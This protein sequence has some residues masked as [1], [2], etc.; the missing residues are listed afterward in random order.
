M[1]FTITV[2]MQD[3][4]VPHFLG[5]LQTMQ[6]L[7]SIGSS[8]VVG[9]YADGDGDFRPKFTVGKKPIR[10]MKFTKPLYGCEKPRSERD[11]VCD[12]FYDAG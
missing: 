7:G 2:E 8:R 3:R 4:W 11:A 10:D 9:I 6:F 12:I 1:K 5:M